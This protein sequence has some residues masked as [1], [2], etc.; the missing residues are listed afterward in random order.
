MRKTI[1][2]LMAALF[3]SSCGPSDK[4]GHPS[5][6]DLYLSWEFVGNNPE[7]GYYSAIFILKN[8]GEQSLS[9]AN[10]NIYFSQMGKGVI[11]HSVT[12]NVIITHMNG[13]LIRISPGKG[14]VLGPGEQ[15][16]IAYQK[17]GSLIKEVEAP[18][19]FYIVF[20]NPKSGEEEVA[21]IQHFD[22]KPFPPM[23]MIFPPSGGIPLPDA[24]WL[25]QQNAGL[26]KL[27]PSEIE[28]IIPTPAVIKPCKGA[29]I[30]MSGLVIRYQKGLENEAGYLADMLEKVMGTRPGMVPGHG[31]GTNLI[32]LSLSKSGSREGYQLKVVEGAGVHIEGGDA[33]GL[34]YGIQSLL[35][36]VPVE[37]WK[38]PQIKLEL[39]CT[40]IT[41][42]PAFHYRGMMLDI[43][44]NYHK[45]ESVRRL[46][47]VMGF[48]KLNKLHLSFTN[49]EAWRLEIPGLPELTDLGGFRGHTR[50]GK[51]RLIPAYG[52]GPFPNPEEGMGSGYLTREDFVELLKFAANH[53]VEV[54]PEI[55]FPGHARAAI[56]AMEARYERLKGEGRMEEA[57]LYRLTDPDDHSVYNSAQNFNDNV[58]CVCKEAPFLF[59]EK[60]VDELAGMYKDAGLEL[61]VIHTGGD[62]VPANSWTGSP[63]CS[64]FL[65]SH[66][67]IDGPSGLQTYFEGRLLGM[68][69]EKGLIMAGWEEIALIK[70]KEGK[71]VPNPDFA[72][73]GMLPYI[74][75]SLGNSLDLGN[76]VANA[77][78]PVILCN[79]DHFYMDLAYNHHPSEPG[80][81]WGGFVNTR[82][83]FTFAPFNVFNTTLTDRY[84]RPIDPETSFAGMEKLEVTARKNISGLEGPLWSET[85]KGKEMLEYYYLPKML[86]L[87]ERAWAGQAEWGDIPE[88]DKRMDAI[89]RDWSGF[90]HTIGYRE[91]PRLDHLFGGY[92]YRLPPP[93]AV[94]QQGR[95]LANVDFPGLFIRYTTDGSEPL[96]DSPVYEGPVE[97]T[98]IISLRSF[99][100]RGRGSLTTK[101]DCTIH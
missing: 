7:Q 67:E 91:M 44:R 55:N 18:A 90:A 21:A 98:G 41:D 54:I 76:R 48:Y 52:S 23:E 58:S 74:W 27:N 26:E 45:P 42:S 9:D 31:E 49:D 6:D 30:L 97:A 82:R 3:L 14:F 25:F 71:W 88:R 22:I 17:P 69:S 68:L 15:V 39:N 59:F 100:T 95:L 57:N 65:N 80:L 92:N 84:N 85:L 5:V 53:H 93:G 56:F 43:A 2:L 78:F 101:V 89:N 99:D 96:A 33:A 72:G 60:V 34:F 11:D 94:V 46:I 32:N 70:N 73:K 75:N 35:A 86:G 19:G 8:T 51:D 13:D 64:D 20:E 4:Q 77:G 50:D 10:W 62:E 61:K 81:Y 87:A 40:E 63:L 28:K 16:E 37:F 83:A 36:M 24:A 1:F 29:E 12:G 79:V 66:P 47:T 38:K